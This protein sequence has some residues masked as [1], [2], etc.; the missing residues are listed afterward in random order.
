MTHLPMAEQ[1]N[2]PEL[3]E[4]SLIWVLS[5]AVA[6]FGFLIVWLICTL[7]GFGSA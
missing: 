7:A 3:V 6:A 5:A 4:T 1:K 2:I